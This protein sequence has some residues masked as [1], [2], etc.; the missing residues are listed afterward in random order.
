[1][2]S[3]LVVTL[4]FFSLWSS[5][6]NNSAKQQQYL[7]KEVKGLYLGMPETALKKARPKVAISND[8]INGYEKFV[9]GDVKEVSY[10]VTFVDKEQNP[11]TERYLY[12][13]IVEYK[14]KAKAIAIAKQLFKKH[15]P[16]E[17]QFDYEWEI[18][19]DD[20]LTLKCWIFNSKICI[21]DKKEF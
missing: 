1:M 13:F 10:Q 19:V 3:L 5:A 8:D 17:S 20:N 7:P 2:K 18:K 4:A 14:T 15:K 11:D 16:V 6:Q 12:E 21:A 9:K